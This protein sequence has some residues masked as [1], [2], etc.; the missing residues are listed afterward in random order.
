MEDSERKWRKRGRRNGE[1]EIVIGGGGGGEGGRELV[2]ENEV[3]L[4]RCE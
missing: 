4:G 1:R 2:Q 3:Q